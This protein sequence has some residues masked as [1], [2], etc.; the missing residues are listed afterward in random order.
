MET[1][2]VWTCVK[3]QNLTNKSQSMVYAFCFVNMSYKYQRGMRNAFGFHPQRRERIPTYSIT[4]SGR[5]WPMSY[6]DNTVEDRMDPGIRI[7]PPPSASGLLG[8]V[9][10]L[11]TG[12]YPWRWMNHKLANDM[13]MWRGNGNATTL[14]F[15]LKGLGILHKKKEED[16]WTP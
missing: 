2:F 3:V 1:I 8:Q 4:S 12:S 11:R 10:V 5:E 6:T 16:M 13:N 9:L 7:H 14:L 15:S